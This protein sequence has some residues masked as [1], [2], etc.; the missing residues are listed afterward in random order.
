M[1]GKLKEAVESLD[2]PNKMDVRGNITLP[3]ETKNGV[4]VSWATDRED[5]VNVN[6]IPETVEVWKHAGRNGHQAGGR[7]GRTHDSD[8][9]AGGQNGD[10]R[11]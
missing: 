7:Y 6:E 4:T 8:P 1:D 11:D 5:I 2:I 9:Y 10:K 3:S